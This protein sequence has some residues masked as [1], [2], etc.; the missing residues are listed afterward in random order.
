MDPATLNAPLDDAE[1]DELDHFLLYDADV[2][3]SMTLDMLDGYL[4][5]LAIGPTTVLPTSWMPRIWGE[6][7][8]G[9]VPPVKDVDRLGR[10]VSLII[11]LSNGIVANLEDPEG[12]VIVPLWSTF[13]DGELERDDAEI[14]A[15]G[16]LAGMNLC[17]DDWAPLLA[18][19]QGS[20]WLRPIRLLGED[21]FGAEQQALTSSPAERERLSLEIPDAVLAMYQ[22]WLPHRRAVLERHA[23]R[24]G[25]ARPGRNGLCPCGS[26]KK[27][28]NCCG[29][30]ADLH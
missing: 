30:A 7:F 3:D 22:Y 19:E 17:E 12:A 24:P 2:D 23:E 26:G 8:T 15:C 25:G 11:R 20:A 29:A 5:A 6:D 4:H 21:D 18:T 16:F 14:W 1:I 10:I 27:F 9:M 13:R 28:K